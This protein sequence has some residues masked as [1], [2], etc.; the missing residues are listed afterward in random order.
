MT[1]MLELLLEKL[2]A[3]CCTSNILQVLIT[4]VKPD[5]TVCILARGI[6]SMYARTQFTSP[7][8][9]EGSGSSC[10]L[11]LGESMNTPRPPRRP[12]DSFPSPPA[13]EGPRNVNTEH[14]FH[15]ALEED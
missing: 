10:R 7:S 11:Q 13:G 9:T 2:W 1:H 4:M 8:S 6:S 14:K 3:E 15:C 5:W 12:M